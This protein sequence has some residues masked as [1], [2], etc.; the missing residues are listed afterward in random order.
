[1]FALAGM[2]KWTLRA[3]IFDQ[4][5]AVVETR[6]DQKQ[7][8]FFER[9]DQLEDEFVLGGADLVEDKAQRC[10]AEQVKQTAELHGNWTQT[11]LALVCADA[12]VKRSRLGQSQGCFVGGNWP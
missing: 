9:L 6:V 11:L 12:F 2:R 5:S 7:I 3:K 8:A 4:G 10:P 1:M